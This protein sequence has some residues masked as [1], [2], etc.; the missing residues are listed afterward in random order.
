PWHASV[1]PAQ[2]P[3]LPVMHGPP[4]P[5]LPSSTRPLQSL[6]LPSQDSG[7]EGFGTQTFGAPFLQ[8]GTTFKHSPTPHAV[9]PS[10]SSTWLLQSSS[11]PLH[12]SGCGWP[13]T[14]TCG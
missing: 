5:G 10:P 13:G 2:T 14:Q 3:W 12:V 6:S 8:N 7:A 11:T 9:L 1:P 4:P